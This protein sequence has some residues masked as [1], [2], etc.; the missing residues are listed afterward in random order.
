M[1][2]IY[3]ITN[4][5]NQKSYIGQTSFT[6]EKRWLEHINNSTKENVKHRPLYAA[7]RKYGKNNFFIEMIEECSIKEVDERE[8]YWIKYYNTYYDGYNATLGGDGTTYI[9]HNTVIQKYS[10]LKNASMVAKEL[11]IHPKHVIKILKANN[12][13]VISSQQVI[14]QKLGKITHMYSLDGEYLRSFSSTSEA[15]NYLIQM[16]I[17]KCKPTTIRYHISEVCKGK[18]KTAGG[19]K[20]SH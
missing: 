10:E 2:Y 20:W 11:N 1:A 16:G 18:R 8:K 13:E 9:D 7:M 5:V 12:I 6:I 4:K 15:G 19:Y 14:K 17:S 3:K